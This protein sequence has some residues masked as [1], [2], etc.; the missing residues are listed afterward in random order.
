[1]SHPTVPCSTPPHLTN[2]IYPIP[3]TISAIPATTCNNTNILKEEI[4]HLN[5]QLGLKD[6]QLKTKELLICKQD[7]EIKLMKKELATN[8]TL[9]IKLEQDK[10]DLEHSLLIQQ[11]NHSN[12]VHEPSAS[13]R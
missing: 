5:S 12:T 4:K 2:C 9:T 7:S 10:K 11:Q 13:R 3:V 6:K 8:R 1:M